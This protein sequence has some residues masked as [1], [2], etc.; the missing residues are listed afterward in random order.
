MPRTYPWLWSETVFQPKKRT[1]SGETLWLPRL[2]GTGMN[3]LK[4][5]GAF[6]LTAASANM[7]I[8]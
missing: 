8:S 5:K 6:P 7:T 3:S 2:R 4:K 1:A